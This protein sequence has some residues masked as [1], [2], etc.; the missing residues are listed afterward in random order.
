[1][2]NDNIGPV[3]LRMTANEE[4]NF[5]NSTGS[6]RT[7]GYYK[8]PHQ[9]KQY[10]KHAHGVQEQQ[11]IQVNSDEFP[12]SSISSTSLLTTETTLDAMVRKRAQQNREARSEGRRWQN[13]LTSNLGEDVAELLKFNQLQ[14]GHLL[15]NHACLCLI[16]THF[17]EIYLS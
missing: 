14:V 1:M 6:A 17:I 12:A 3:F 4:N 8:I 9:A 2:N 10:L 5:F 11:S 15:N 13:L 7:E 16:S